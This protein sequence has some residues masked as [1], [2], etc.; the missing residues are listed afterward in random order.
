MEQVSGLLAC[1]AEACDQG[2][3]GHSLGSHL[4]V[5][6]GA[7]GGDGEAGGSWV[8]GPRSRCGVGGHL[9]LR[10]PSL[11]SSQGDLLGR[12]KKTEALQSGY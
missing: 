8:S 9:Q 11:F 7:S 1:I 5:G 2:Y 4:E 6:G 3:R 12:L 10:E